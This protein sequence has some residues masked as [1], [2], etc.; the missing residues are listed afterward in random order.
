M[1]WPTVRLAP[2]TGRKSGVL[3]LFTGVGTATTIKRASLS[4]LGS[5]VNS[6]EVFLIASPTSFVES[7][8]FLYSLTRFSL[9]SKPI[10]PM[11][12]ENST[13]IGIPT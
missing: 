2:S 1:F 7:I 13:A 4:F 6:T 9:I 11:C 8:P 10:T 3:S 5:K 12:L